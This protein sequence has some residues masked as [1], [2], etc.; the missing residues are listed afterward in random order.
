MSVM[1]VVSPPNA[2][3]ASGTLEAYINKACEIEQDRL[4]FV[5]LPDGCEPRDGGCRVFCDTDYTYRHFFADFGPLHLG[6]VHDFCKKLGNIFED[7]ALRKKRV[8][9]WSTTHPHRR[10]N[11]VVLI[12]AYAVSEDRGSIIVQPAGGHQQEHVAVPVR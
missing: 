4:F 5:S 9:V 10:S 6:H 11:A 2:L 7:Q 8:Y 3:D 12:L 1:D